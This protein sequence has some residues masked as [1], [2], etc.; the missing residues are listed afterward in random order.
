MIK[1]AIDAMGG[2]YAPEEIVKGCNIAI[3]RFGDIELVLYGD[4]TEINRFLVPNPRVS[5]V[6]APRKL[7]MG[8]EDPIR[9]IRNNKNSS[10][11]MSF[12]AVK[13]GAAQGV[14][15]AGPTQGAIVAAHVIVRRIKGMKRVG[16]C[17]QLPQIGGKTRL[18]LDVGANVEMRPEHLEQL[19]IFASIYLRET[20]G[21]NHPLVG[22]LN[23]GTEE[24]KGRE[25]DIET[26][27]LL[28]DHPLVQFYGN[29]EPKE[30][31]TTACDILLTDGFTG[32]MV[33]KTTEGTAKAIG[34]ILKEEIKR[35][36]FG[37]IGFLFMKK[38]L[39]NFKKRLSPDEIGGANIFGVD[40]IIVKAHGSSNAYAFS[41]AIGQARL[42]IKGDVI[43][44]MK[45]V[46]SE[47][48]SDAQ[49]DA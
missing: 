26:F 9:E 37:K 45:A 16:L 23:I 27:K 25:L 33:M 8:E 10:M 2:D 30:L 42:A 13:D 7:E 35:T 34:M 43:N 29:V 15:T 18:L 19:A 5:I 11:V 49:S 41:S 21:I 44:K 32:N 28:T 3:D 48:I 31:L 24:G 22:L 6:H 20:Q 14:V 46:L 17:P 12:Q 47:E 39:E 36:F 4:E 40:G 38:N 1:I